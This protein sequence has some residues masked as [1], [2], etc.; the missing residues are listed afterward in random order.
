MQK[1]DEEKTP[2]PFTIQFSPGT[3][4][5]FRLYIN[6]VNSIGPSETSSFKIQSPKIFKKIAIIGNNESNQVTGGKIPTEE[7]LETEQQ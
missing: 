4:T 1:Y 7:D 5:Q 3:S 2:L 6:A